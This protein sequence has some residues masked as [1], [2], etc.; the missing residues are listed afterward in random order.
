MSN[1]G[2]RRRGPSGAAEGPRAVLAAPALLIGLGAA[3]RVVSVAARLHGRAGRR[4]RQHRA[5]VQH[6]ECELTPP[7][8]TTGERRTAQLDVPRNAR[9]RARPSARCM[10]CDLHERRLEAATLP[11][12]LCS[13]LP[14]PASP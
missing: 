7:P 3:R 8:H 11:P 2:L 10:I 4:R 9:A 6:R 1:R 12:Q 5:A 14:R 13:F